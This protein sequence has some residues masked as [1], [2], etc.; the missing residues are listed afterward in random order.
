MK[1]RAHHTQCV[2][3]MKSDFL[4]EKKEYLQDSETRVQSLEKKA[5]QVS[6]L[7]QYMFYVLHSLFQI[8]P[9]D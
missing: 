9:S 8:M 4:K 6:I 1:L 2:Q 3:K 7:S 5:N